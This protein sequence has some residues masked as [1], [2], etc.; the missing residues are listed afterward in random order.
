MPTEWFYTVNGQQAP[1]P[2]TAVQLK[3]LAAN[4]QLQ[5]TDLVWQEG[6]ANWAPANTI[7]GLFPGRGAAAEPAAD[8]PPAKGRGR[9]KK[10]REEEVDE[11]ESSGLLDLHPLLVVLL[12]VCTVG[13]FGLIY[14]FTACG[15]YAK[16]FTREADSSGRPLGAAR[17]PVFVLLLSYLTFGIYCFV[18]AY[19]VMG[20]CR[21][22][23]GRKD[24]D[25]RVE[26][27]L[28]LILP[29]YGLYVF[30]VRLPELVRAA[31]AAAKAPE[32]LVVNHSYLF[33]VPCLAPALP[34][35]LMAQQEALN[36]V[37][38]QSP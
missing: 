33:F 6:M 3:Q 36:Q 26:V 7:K 2:A 8:A 28:M 38:L 19:K 27:S 12:T 34:L 31:Q 21:A 14:A 16:P 11:G 23:A 32:S 18:W 37:W 20:E 22:F 4:G 1:T 17:H 29:P 13:V 15:A 30:V 5:P 10:R 24:A 25:P 35:L 9:G